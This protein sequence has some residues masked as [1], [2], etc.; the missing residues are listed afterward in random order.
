VAAAP[1]IRLGVMEVGRASSVGS[2]GGVRPPWR[3]VR[4]AD[5]LPGDGVR[6]GEARPGGDV[7]PGEPRRG[8]PWLAPVTH[9]L[10]LRPGS[11]RRRR[12]PGVGSWEMS[13]AWERKC[14][15]GE[16]SRGEEA[17]RLGGES[18]GE[19]AGVGAASREEVGAGP[20]RDE[21]SDEFDSSVSV[22]FE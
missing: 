5:A 2:G 16:E 21:T 20:S 22:G 1:W 6:T 4:S 18:R 17:V 10:V 12:P 14:G 13:A 9:V 19:E 8:P 3:R 7:R 11:P 15:V